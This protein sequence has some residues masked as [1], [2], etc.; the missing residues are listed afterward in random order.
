M[1]AFREALVLRTCRYTQTHP[2]I[3]FQRYEKARQI[4]DAQDSYC[5]KVL[6]GEQEDIANS[7]FPHDLQ[8]EALVDVLRGR[9]KAR[10]QFDSEPCVQGSHFL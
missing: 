8:W 5:D 2:P 7:E 6:S 10:P 4:K 9:V 3:H 1:W